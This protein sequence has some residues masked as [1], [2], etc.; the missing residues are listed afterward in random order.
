M[1]NI[2][3]KNTVR[4]NND[5]DTVAFAD[6]RYGFNFGGGI[7]WEVNRAMT[8]RSMHADPDI[9]DVIFA[10]NVVL[11][12]RSGKEVRVL[13]IEFRDTR[14]GANHGYAITVHGNNALIRNV[15]FA[16]IVGSAIY[17]GADNVRIRDS[18]FSD[19]GG[20][21]VLIDTDEDIAS[22]AGSQ[23]NARRNLRFLNNIVNNTGGHALTFDS[24]LLHNST[25]P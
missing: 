1:S 12:L 5:I 23:D 14:A 16:D 9:D 21:A 22:D 8:F 24:A 4:N 7:L 13:G 6:G 2:H 11:D 19:I 18:T 15:V 25:Y 10:D 3:V 17:V 20:N